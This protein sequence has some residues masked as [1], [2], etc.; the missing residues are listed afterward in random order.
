MKNLLLICAIFLGLTIGHTQAQGLGKASDALKNEMQKLE[1][2][3]GKWKGEAI[4]KQRNGPD[5]K[6]IQDENIYFKLDNTI[7]IFEG[8]GRNPQNLN[9]I[10]F[11]AFAVVSYDEHKKEFK[12]TSHL[13]DGSQ[14]QAYFKV[15]GENH[16][17]W[18]FDVQNN[19]KMRYDIKLDPKAKTWYETGEYSPDGATWYP[20]IT[21]NLTKV[22]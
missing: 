12:M 19:A 22:D 8:T 17:E 18:G 3:T 16:F 6:I 1:Y 9:E 7:L 20:F 5:T 13:K 15:L 21:L 14:T 4:A 11:N 2:F 10:T